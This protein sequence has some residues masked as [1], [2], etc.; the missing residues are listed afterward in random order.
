MRARSPPRAR[1]SAARAPAGVLPSGVRPSDY[2]SRVRK[3]KI[4]ARTRRDT[5][6][7]RRRRSRRR[8]SGTVGR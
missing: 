1:G 7:R 5:P 4:T 6:S 3:G 8:R 2:L